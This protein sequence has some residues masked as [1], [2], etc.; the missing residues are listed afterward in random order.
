MESRDLRGAAANGGV[1][2]A[3]AGL[4]AGLIDFVESAS[5]EITPN[6]KDLPASLAGRLPSGT[7]LYV[8][9]TPHFSVADVAETACRVE[10]AG[11]KASP[12]IAARRIGARGEL[13]AALGR[14]VE[15]GITRAL[16]VAGDVPEPAGPFASTLD[17]IESG[18]LASA[19]ISTLGVAGHPEGHSRIDT[20]VLWGALRH[21]QDYGDRTGT[22]VHVV[23]QFGFNPEALA[24]WERGLSEHGIRLPVHVG[25]AGPASLSSL[26]KYSMLCGI[27]ASLGSLMTNPTAAGALR[28]LVTSADEMLVRIVQ[29]R[30]G[31]LE[32]RFIKP[33]F[34]SFGGTLRTVEWLEAVRAGRFDIDAL[35]GR[36]ILRS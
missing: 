17:V 32:R 22:R 27:G 21:K 11:F 7:T 15:N 9:H 36:L 23:S 3:K 14:L 10:R 20:A 31:G 28:T 12:H 4:R 33:H 29:V 35:A 16:L 18:A 19:G 25:I 5:L 2:G 13:D 6:D 8:A 30:Q 26:I 34:F 1:T 24:E